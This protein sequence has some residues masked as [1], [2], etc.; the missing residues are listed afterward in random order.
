MLREF[1]GWK[2]AEVCAT[3]EARHAI[4]L[5]EP[6]V[7]DYR[8]KVEQLFAQGLRP[9]RGVQQML[10]ALALPKCVASSGPPAKIAQSLQL[11]G[12][13]QHFGE[14]IFSS[15]VVQSWK[16]DPGLFLHAAHAMG[17]APARCAVIED[18][19]VGIRAALAAGMR[20]F[21]YNE[22][23]PLSEQPDVVVFNDMR[24]L[25]ELLA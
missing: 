23:G 13:K 17:F 10:A 9:V 22:E 3:L 5:P 16:P 14:N 4:A 7:A 21:R 8:R 25:P 15:Y 19:D 18:S 12:L 1:K 20:A 24:L 6:F 11:S 2:L